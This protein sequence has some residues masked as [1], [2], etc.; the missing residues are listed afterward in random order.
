MAAEKYMEN[1][2]EDLACIVCLELPRDIPVYQCGQGHLLCKEC[3]PKCKNICPICRGA[4]GTVR[5]LI[6]EKVS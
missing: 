6:A 2:E 3:H 4:L 1:F 5:S